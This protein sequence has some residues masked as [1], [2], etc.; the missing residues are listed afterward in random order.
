MKSIRRKI[1][2]EF[3]RDLAL[4][5]QD[6]R[7]G[8]SE[9]NILSDPILNNVLGTFQKD[10]EVLLRSYALSLG[11]DMEGSPASRIKTKDFTHQLGKIGGAA[12]G[13]FA[14]GAA[15][16]ATVTTK[17]TG[18]LF[19]KK[20]VDVSLAAVIAEFLGVSLAPVTVG[21]SLAGAAAGVVIASKALKN[22]CWHKRVEE[23]MRIYETEIVPS[24]LQWLEGAMD[25]ADEEHLRSWQGRDER[26]HMLPW[27]S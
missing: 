7:K 4:L 17:T 13:W 9:K 26:P 19:W 8:L 24:L 11:V 5:G 12:G 15:A 22:A 3:K 6:L 21:L 18:W 10:L 14:G 27:Q 23:V 20:T 16:A 25:E 2:S 1:R